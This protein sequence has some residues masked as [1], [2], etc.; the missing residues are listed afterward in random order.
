MSVVP[1]LRTSTDVKIVLH[2]GSGM[3]KED[4]V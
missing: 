3:R 4:G 2:D 1:D